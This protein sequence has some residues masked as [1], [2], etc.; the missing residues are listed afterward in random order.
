[1]SKQL[2][3]KFVITASDWEPQKPHLRV[4]CYAAEQALKFGLGLCLTARNKEEVQRLDSQRQPI[5]VELREVFVDSQGHE[6]DEEGE[7]TL[8]PNAHGFT[9]L[10]KGYGEVSDG[11]TIRPPQ[12]FI[13][14]LR[15]PKEVQ[16]GQSKWKLRPTTAAELDGSVAQAAAD[17]ERQ[18]RDLRARSESLRRS[19]EDTDVARAAALKAAHD[20]AA[21]KA[22]EAET[23]KQ[24]ALK[25]TEENKKLREQIAALK[26][27]KSDKPEKAAKEEVAK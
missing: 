10:K 16:V 7:V 5:V 3:R 20:E 21:S 12:L 23:A 25:A 4:D 22:A 6:Y 24:E 13:P 1:M 14:A 11:E 2:Y 18:A 26:A 8:N 27:A 17:L 19:H 9:V 15:D